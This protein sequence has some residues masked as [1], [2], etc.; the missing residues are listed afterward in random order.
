MGGLKDKMRLT[1]AVFLI[2]AASL[3]G[4]PPFSGF[5]SKDAVLATAWDAGQWG[6]FAVGAV[7]AG[8][9]A[10]YTFRM[11]GLIFY[12][13]SSEQLEEHHPHEAGPLGWVPVRDPGGDDR[14]H[15]R[16]RSAPQHRRC[17][18]AAAISYLQG[19]SPAGAAHHR[20]PQH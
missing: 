5:W 10:F 16:P 13:K 14:G 15:R 8:I 2:A 17:A 7:T 19:L 12:G 18:E 20:S 11:F 1:F 3:S 9:T 4:I 6:L